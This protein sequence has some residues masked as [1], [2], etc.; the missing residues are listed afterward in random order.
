MK[1]IHTAFLGLGNVGCGVYR[2]LDMQKEAFASR[3]DLAFSVDRILVRD[4]DR[5]RRV[6]VSR[7]R[8]TVDVDEIVNDP[9]ITL[10]AEF[11][12]GIEPAATYMERMLLAGKSVVTA[13]KQALANAWPR[14]SAA[15]MKTGAGLYFEASVC[16]GIPVIETL[17][18]SLQSN[19]VESIMGIINGTCNYILSRMSEGME[20]EDAL[21][22]A[23]EKGLAEPDPTADV[24]GADATCKLAI[25]STLAFGKSVTVDD[26]Y[27]EGISSLTREALQF[28]ADMG[29]TLKSLAVAKEKDGRLQLHVHPA[30]LPNR[31]PIA[32]VSGAY[33]AVY[34]RGNAVEDIMLSGKGAGDM[35]TASS[36]VSDMVKVATRQVHPAVDF[37]ESNRPYLDEDWICGNFLCLHVEDKSGVMAKLFGILS[38]YGLSAASV[39]QPRRAEKA[40]RVPVIVTT[41]PCREQAMRAALVDIRALPEVGSVL[42]IRM[43]EME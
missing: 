31:H 38:H 25:L 33:N 11:M 29:Y 41:Y 30:F 19:R 42:R 15:A 18:S 12:G 35:P 3:S 13:N 26:V 39:T 20:Y 43:E 23:Q 36:V 21:A 7:D 40:E 5:P 14:L 37:Q 8:L 32:S 16:G 27:C 24:E 6:K 10:V 2:L 17:L 28:G 9:D 34:I 22:E 4:L 1:T